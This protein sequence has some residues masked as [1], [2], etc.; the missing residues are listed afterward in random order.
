MSLPLSDSALVGT[1]LAASALGLLVLTSSGGNGSPQPTQ[2]TASATQAVPAQSAALA[3]LGAT[4]VGGTGTVDAEFGDQVRSYLL[5]NPEVIFEAVAAYESR[6]AEMQAD[7]DRAVLAANEDGL[8]NDANSWVGGNPEGDVSLVAFI[9]YRCGFCKRAH[10]ELEAL[11]ET[12]DN[13]RL[14]VKEFPILG[15][16]SEMSSRFAIA[17][18][19]LGGDDV[20]ATVHDRLMRHDGE[21]SPDFLAE[22]ASAVELEVDTVFEEMSS[23]HVSDVI[24]ANYALAQRLQISGTPTFV[25]EDEMIR[26]YVDADVLRDMIMAQRD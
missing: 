8:F 20:Y 23:P 19:T 13:L 9:D 4:P 25:L 16:E 1:C 17:A 26:G 11:L 24:A 6:N 15:P 2:P 12:D 22:L 10:D 7:M 5:Q 18:L 3:Q 21:I 14:I